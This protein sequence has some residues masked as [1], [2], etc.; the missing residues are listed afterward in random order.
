[1]KPDY[2]EQHRR[3]ILDAIAGHAKASKGWQTKLGGLAV[4][5]NRGDSEA[6]TFLR[7]F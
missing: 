3:R 4:R 5:D 2:R 6:E 1:M 7:K